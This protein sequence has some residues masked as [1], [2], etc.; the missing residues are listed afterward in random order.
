[1]VKYWGKMLRPEDDKYAVLAKIPFQILAFHAP[2]EITE[3]EWDI[4]RT[5]FGGKGK[6]LTGRDGVGF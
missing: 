6:P 1:M 2:G 3:L 5:A 4:K